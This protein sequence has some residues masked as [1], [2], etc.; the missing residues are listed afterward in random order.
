MIQGMFNEKQPHVFYWTIWKQKPSSQWDWAAERGHLEGLET[1][2]ERQSRFFMK[3]I[4]ALEP[5]E[6]E[7]S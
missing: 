2:A 6:S 7:C 5:I 1:K 3:L 4:K